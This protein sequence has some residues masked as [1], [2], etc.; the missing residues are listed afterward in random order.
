MPLRPVLIQNDKRQIDLLSCKLFDFLLV[1]FTH[2]AVI[3]NT[4]A[5][6]CHQFRSP[7]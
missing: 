3:V 1:I 5:F 2:T 6:Q 7:A 4:L